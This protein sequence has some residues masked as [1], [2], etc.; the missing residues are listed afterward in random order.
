MVNQKEGV[1]AFNISRYSRRHCFELQSEPEGGYTIFR[2]ITSRL[3][4]YGKT[5]EEAI[6][7]IKDAMEGWL[8][9]HANRACRYPN[10]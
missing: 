6:E 5:F 1:K 10:S 4:L 8:Q 3:S 2:A 7:K 9:W